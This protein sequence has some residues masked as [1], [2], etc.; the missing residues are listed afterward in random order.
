MG[1]YKVDTIGIEQ[2]E[3]DKILGKIQNRNPTGKLQFIG[4]KN[5]TFVE[6]GKPL[7]SAFW[8]AGIITDVANDVN[9]ILVNIDSCG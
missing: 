6:F 8:A 3:I 1:N 5:N 7:G 4:I 9:Y 2:S